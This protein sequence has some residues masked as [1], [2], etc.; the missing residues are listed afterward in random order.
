MPLAQKVYGIEDRRNKAG[1]VETMRDTD[2]NLSIF[3]NLCFKFYLIKYCEILG[4]EALLGV[5]GQDIL[6][7]KSIENSTQISYYQKI[8]IVDLIINTEKELGVQ[9]SS[10]RHCL[11]FLFLHGAISEKQF[12]ECFTLKPAAIPAYKLR[13]QAG[14]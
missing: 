13:K 14:K 8:R 7:E 9:E 5:L 11:L 12:N 6:Q 2:A 1:Q 3:D 4:L 10:W